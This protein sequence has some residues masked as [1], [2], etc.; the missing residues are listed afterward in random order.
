VSARIAVVVTARPSWAKLLPVCNALREAGF[1]LDVIACAYALTH[2]RSGV[3]DVMT[4][5]GWAPTTKLHAAID[6]NT[7]ESSALTTGMLTVRLG[8]HFAA[9]EPAGVIVCADRHETLAATISAAYLNIPICHLQGGE[10]SGSIDNRVRNAN[11][12]LSD[13]HCV[14]NDTAYARLIGAGVPI[15]RLWVTG[16]P[17]IDVARAAK[18]DKPFDLYELNQHGVGDE[19]D[20]EQQFSLVMMHPTTTHPET[21]S[22]DIDYAIEDAY[23]K[24]MQVV[25]FWPGADAGM[26]EAGFYLRDHAFPRMRML[27]SLP[28]R[29]FLKLL[30]QAAYAVG[31]SSALI[32]EASYYGI[33]RTILG[34]RQQ[35]RA[36][37]AEPS[38]LYGDGYAAPRI[39]QVCQ[40]M[41]SK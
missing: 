14:S 26:D 21:A 13:W 2:T 29:R 15:D 37:T 39:A 41:V 25:T 5:D 32:R 19:V 40:M 38:T 12:A 22:D 28:P 18:D 34:D 4:C 33:P 6:A 27:R 10:V 31:N 16:C 23:S 8:G 36:W 11:T 9:T 30:S 1:E 24:N 7:L 35:G 17:S 3:V 20:P